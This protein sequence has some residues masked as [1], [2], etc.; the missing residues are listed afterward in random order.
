MNEQLELQRVHRSSFDDPGDPRLEEVSRRQQGNHKVSLGREIEEVSR[1]DENAALLE[2]IEGELLV[3]AGAGHADDGG[4]ATFDR[5][6]LQ[7]GPRGDGP[8][9]RLEVLLRAGTDRI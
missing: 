1:M 6:Q 5:E 4:P 8:A 9:K 2:Q 3:A 7:L